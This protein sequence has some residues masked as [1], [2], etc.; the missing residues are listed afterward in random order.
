MARRASVTSPAATTLTYK[1]NANANG[2]DSFTY[3]IYDGH[4]GSATG[5]V[6]VTITPVD[7]APIALNDTTLTVPE[8]AGPRALAVLANDIE[9][10]GE[11]LHIIAKTNGAHGIVAIT[12]GGT[13]LT[14]DPNQLYSGTDV[15]TY[16]IS[17]GTTRRPQQSS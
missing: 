2:S 7:D 5:T 17:T 16:T 10:D 4:G 1:P 11:T 9:Y 13:G 12:G 15:F 8:S 6:D 3:T 14:Y